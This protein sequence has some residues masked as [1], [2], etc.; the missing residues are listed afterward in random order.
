MGPIRRLIGLVALGALALGAVAATP[1][2]TDGEGAVDTR[3]QLLSLALTD[4]PGVGDLDGSIGTL[5][6]RAGTVDTRSASLLLEGLRA[7]DTAV[8]VWEASSAEGPASGSVDVP[9]EAPGVTGGVSLVDY[10]AEADP[11]V[12][13]Q[14]S[15]LTGELQAG[16]L[17]LAASLGD[18]GIVSQVTSDAATGVTELSVDG[19][20]LGVGDLL[21]EGLLDELPLG[22]LLDLLDELPIDLDAD[23]EAAL[24]L[25]D[26][27]LADLDG[28]VDLDAERRAVFDQLRGLL[29]DQPDVIDAEQVLADAEELLDDAEAAV[30]AAVGDLTGLLDDLAGA[31]QLLS[32]AESVVDDAQELVDDTVALIGSLEDELSDVEDDLALLG[33]LSGSALLNLLGTL[34]ATYDTDCG[35]LISAVSCYVDHLEGLIDDLEQELADAADDLASAE[36]DLADAQQVVDG[37]EADVADAEQVLADAQSLL[38]DAQDAVADARDALEQTIRDVATSP[39]TLDLLDLLEGLT[40]QL[41]DLLDDLTGQLALLPDLAEL[42][43]QLAGLIGDT[44]LLDLG[45]LAIEVEV[46]ADAAGASSEVA[47]TLAD[48]EV[49]GLAPVPEL[50]CQQ[51]DASLSQVEG[52]LA[53]LLGALPVDLPV[54]VE[55]GGLQVSTD[56]DHDPVDGT[57]AAT[58]SVSGLRIDVGSVELTDLVDGLTDELAGL[59]DDVLGIIDDLGDLDVG[60][61]PLLSAQAAANPA[62]LSGSLDEL[63][64]VVDGLP[65]GDAL[66]GLRT[67]GLD[68]SVAGIVTDGSFLAAAAPGDD[69]PT[70]PMDPSDPVDP[71]DPGDLDPQPIEPSDPPPGDPADPEPDDP[72]DDPTPGDDP[73][74]GAPGDGPSDD[75]D[76]ELPRTG[77]GLVPL[78]GALLVLLGVGLRR[79]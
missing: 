8:P 45:R 25:L 4:L 1:Q 26:E 22:L 48:V 14:V 60:D 23:L 46:R 36:S 41:T 51:L 69:T 75:P 44:P 2:A 28:I 66:A 71:G 52:I 5:T 40:E 18:R 65:L 11:D 56:T 43:D 70:D 15:A 17:G 57:S 73:D 39:E 29:G 9:I 10:L 59:V 50:D 78:L 33:S 12:L 31:E 49:L 47:C 13:A 77:G 37:L 16:P 58:A 64:G 67:V 79:P 27:L 35:I 61:L 54:A 19:L 32:D 6:S 74:L 30:D 42:R 24:D 63:A 21:P 34:D 68:L 55:I 53:D 76:P 3:L 72:A 7:G 20:R 38:D 62:S